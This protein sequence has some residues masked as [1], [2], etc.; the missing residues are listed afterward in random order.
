MEQT[1][2]ETDGMQYRLMLP[3]GGGITN[4]L[5]SVLDASLQK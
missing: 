5:A 1:D 2:R 4:D 3:Y